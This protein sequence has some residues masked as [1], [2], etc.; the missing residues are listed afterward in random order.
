MINYSIRPI[1]L[2]SSRGMETCKW[3]VW[4]QTGGKMAEW[5][6]GPMVWQQSMYVNWL[7]TDRGVDLQQSHDCV[8]CHV[9]NTNKSNGSGR[10]AAE[11]QS[12]IVVV[13]LKQRWGGLK[14]SLRWTD[15]NVYLSWTADVSFCS[16]VSGLLIK[17]RFMPDRLTDCVN[18]RQGQA[19]R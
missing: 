6:V 3:D 9:T 15:T 5:K 8:A 2:Q 12:T 1:Q 19:F 11:E 13:N 4:T 14:Y 16:G 17:S 18:A 7:F 10:P